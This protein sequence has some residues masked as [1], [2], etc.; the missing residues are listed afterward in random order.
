MMALDVAPR[1]RQEYMYV[2]LV[3]VRKTAQKCVNL[4][5]GRWKTSEKAGRYKEVLY[6]YPF[7]PEIPEYTCTQTFF[8]ESS[9]CP[10][11]CCQLSCGL[12]FR[13]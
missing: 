8:P 10:L 12:I 9:A 2:I 6:E 11:S 3:R 4:Q 5:T 7:W 13:G 1:N